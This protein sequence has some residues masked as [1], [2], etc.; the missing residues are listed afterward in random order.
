M[1]VVVK[2]PH[3]EIVI[4]G[5]ISDRIINFLQKEFGN[6]FEIIDD[7]APVNIFETDWYKATKSNMKP[8]DFIRAYRSKKGW[9]Q[10]ELGANLGGIPRQHVSNM[11][12]GIRPVSVKMAQKLSI[13]FDTEISRFLGHDER[14]LFK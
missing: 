1:Q 2:T 9:T 5:M 11:E 10:K 12:R 7:D 4:K 14:I 3:T 8:G 13:L 6:S